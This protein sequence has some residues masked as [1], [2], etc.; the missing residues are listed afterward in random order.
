MSTFLGLMLL[1]LAATTSPALEN[2][3]S[4]GTDVPHVPGTPKYIIWVKY[5]IGIVRNQVSILHEEVSVL[6][7]SIIVVSYCPSL[8][9]STIH[10][11]GTVV[12]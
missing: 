11:S 9:I 5:R 10:D 12:I 1:L 3:L 4:D 2:N 8:F 6:V 7:V